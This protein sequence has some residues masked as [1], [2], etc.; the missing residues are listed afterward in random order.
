L[1]V[2]ILSIVILGTTLLMVLTAIINLFY[3]KVPYVPT[4]NKVLKEIFQHLEIKKNSVFYD[5]GCGDGR[6]LFEMERTYKTQNIG[7]EI[8]P[9][10]YLLAKFKKLTSQSKSEI[11]LQNFMSAD[12][13]KADIIFCYLTPEMLEKLS[14]KIKSECKKGTKIITHTFSFKSIPVQKLIPK[15]QNLPNIYIYEI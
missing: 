6:I 14:K 15:K 7:F 13:S 11:L 3:L 1:L 2:D 9:I 12:F 5:L 10:P 4:K 8:A